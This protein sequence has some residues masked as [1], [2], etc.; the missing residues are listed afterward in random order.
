MT[1]RSPEDV[2]AGILRIPVGGVEKIVPT[3]PLRASREWQR[4][5]FEKI[6]E[7]RP[8]LSAGQTP[9]ALDALARLSL[10]TI[11]DLVGAYDRTSALGGREWLE[12]NADPAQLYGAARAMAG[13]AL[14]PFG[15]DA[16]S[17]VGLLP[18]LVAALSTPSSTNGPSPAGGS[19]HV[20]S[21]SAST[22]RS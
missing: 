20:R 21:K 4:L 22:P 6:G 8:V 17:L 5:V 1:D 19:I 9:E 15:D 13:V 10:D 12:E 18:G 2:L 16:K 7:F 14:F 11:L 3:L